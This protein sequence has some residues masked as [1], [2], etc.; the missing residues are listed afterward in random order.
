M[1][2]S[3]R[4]VASQADLGVSG[5][6]Q[7]PDRTVSRRRAEQP[8]VDGLDIRVDAIVGLVDKQATV[9]VD[10]AARRDEHADERVGRVRLDRP[11][12]PRDL[13]EFDA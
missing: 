7:A 9:A 1:F 5:G 11:R 6:G 12:G 13:H 8:T 10:R 2:L 3:R 4:S